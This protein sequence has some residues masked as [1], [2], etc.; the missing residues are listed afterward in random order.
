MDSYKHLLIT[1]Y[2]ASW[3]MV[4]FEQIPWALIVRN[5]TM[6]GGDQPDALRPRCG[7]V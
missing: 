2:M 4:F 5:Y 1:N 7:G 3:S 6:L